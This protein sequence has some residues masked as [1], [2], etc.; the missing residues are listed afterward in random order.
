[1][2]IK[3][4]EIELGMTLWQKTRER[5]GNTT[6]RTDAVFEVHIISVDREKRTAMASWNGNRARIWFERDLK[7]LYRE[8]PVVKPSVFR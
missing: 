4:E 6:M 5:M 3:F 8:R 2:A 1:M 7:K